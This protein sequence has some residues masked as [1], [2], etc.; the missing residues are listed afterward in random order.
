VTDTPTAGQTGTGGGTIIPTPEVPDEDA[1][2]STPTK[3]ETV[4]K[5]VSYGLL[6]LLAASGIGLLLLYLGWRL[7]RRSAANDE[8]QFLESLLTRAKSRHD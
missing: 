2:D 5:Y 1:D 4:I 3:T 6:V 7:G 8:D